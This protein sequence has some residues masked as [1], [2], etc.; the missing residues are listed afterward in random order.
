VAGAQLVFPFARRVLADMTRDG[1]F[2]SLQLEPI[3]FAQMYAER[4]QRESA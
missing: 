3:D 4:R 1:G 2:P